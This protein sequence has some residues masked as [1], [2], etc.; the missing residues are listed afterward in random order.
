M[1]GDG[2]R[3]D[4]A[5]PTE[6]PPSRVDDLGSQ[7]NLRATDVAGLDP[8]ALP[9]LPPQ[10]LARAA[11]CLGLTEQEARDLLGRDGSP[12]PTSR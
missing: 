3:T 9:A 8:I 2:S 12:A 7:V 6:G 4:A 1:R 11:T 5:S 10:A